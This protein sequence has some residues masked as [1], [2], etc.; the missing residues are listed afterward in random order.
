[1]VESASLLE[2]GLGILEVLIPISGYNH[3]PQVAEEVLDG[4]LHLV[5]AGGGQYV[6]GIGWFHQ[7]IFVQQ[8]HGQRRQAYLE[9]RDLGRGV[10]FYIVYCGKE[11]GSYR[12]FPS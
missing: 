11:R 9:M 3:L 7:Q 1:M 2:C 6:I 4:L 12:V 10:G 8:N 5:D